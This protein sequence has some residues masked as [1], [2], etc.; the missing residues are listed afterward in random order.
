MW[1]NIVWGH[2]ASTDLIHWI[3]LPTAMYPDQWYDSNGVW[4]GST[5]KLPDGRLVVLYTGATDDFVQVQNLAYPANLSDPLLIDWVKYP[6]N[7]VI[8]PPQGVRDHDFRDPTTAW[9]TPQGKWRISIGSKHNRT[10]IALLYDTED[11]KTFELLGQM[12]HGVS[13]TGMW[14]CVD[15]YPVSKTKKVGLDTSE[16]GDDVKHVVKTSLDD[17][18]N[19]YYALGSYDD[20][21]KWTP[22]DP[23]IDVGIGLRYDY[24]LFY[25]SKTFFDDDKKRRVLWGWIP[26][27]DS[28]GADIK[29]GWASLQAVPRTVLYDKKTGSNL[30]QWPVEE[31][32]KLRSKSWEF[33]HDLEPG[34]AVPLKVDDASQLDIVVELELDEESVKRA[35]VETEP[36]DSCQGIGGGSSKRGALGPFGIMVSADKDLFEYTSLYFYISKSSNGDLNTFFCTDL[37]RSSEA[38]D[39]LKPIYGS[40]VPVLKGEKLTMRILVIFF[41]FVSNRSR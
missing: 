27:S 24:G 3:H 40:I 36:S 33:N 18:R 13:G 29:K 10:G 30:L 37:T 32:E 17:D 14:E 23:K 22:D 34:C 26:E 8:E 38:R 41:V 11:F 20:S 16:N 21:G 31:I 15:F 4:T 25:A 28:V 12:L 39:V 1:G 19:D 35:N 9:L 7:P 2:A 6:G 5:T